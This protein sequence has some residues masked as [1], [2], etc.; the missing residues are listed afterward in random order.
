MTPGPW[1]IL[2]IIL[3]IVLVFGAAR[4][5]VIAENL[6]KG[7]KSFRRGLKDEDAAEDKG[8]T[9]SI[10]QSSKDKTSNKE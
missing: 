9:K 10:K 8:E 5:P 6:A 3:L 7:I 4:V 2:I 1:Q